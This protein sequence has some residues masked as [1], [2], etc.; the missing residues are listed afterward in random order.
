MKI[1][2][3]LRFELLINE[4]IVLTSNL[5][6]GSIFHFVRNRTNNIRIW[7][8]FRYIDLNYKLKLLITIFICF[9]A[10]YWSEK[11]VYLGTK[12]ILKNNLVS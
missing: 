5:L 1:L 6:P 3:L 8:L 4:W 11:N 10:L 2:R 9:V 7:T 12:A